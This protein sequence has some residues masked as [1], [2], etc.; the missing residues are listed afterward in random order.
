MR[1]SISRRATEAGDPPG[2]ASAGMRVPAINRI[3]P[4]LS[5]GAEVVGR[6]TGHHSRLAILVELKQFA[7]GPDIYAIECHVD[8]Q[9]AH[10]ANIIAQAMRLQVAPL[11]LEFK[12]D[13][14]GALDL[15]AQFGARALQRSRLAQRQVRA[16]FPPRDQLVNVL[17]R[18]EQRILIEP[19]SMALAKTGEGFAIASCRVTKCLECLAQQWQLPRDDGAEIHVA[20]GKLRFPIDIAGVQIAALHQTV[21]ADQQRIPREGREALVGRIAVAGRPERQHLPD[22]LS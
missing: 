8:G 10:D 6:N 14:L 11:A 3:A 4:Q 2:K 7:I 19:G 15:V 12:L 16:P 20:G 21:D 13:E 1:S 17:Q 9:V 5:G 22:V 18:H